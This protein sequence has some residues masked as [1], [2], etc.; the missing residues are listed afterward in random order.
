ME[1]CHEY[2]ENHPELLSDIAYT[3]AVRREHLTHR[4]Y[5]ISGVGASHVV[6]PSVRV[7]GAVADIVMTFSGQGAQWAKMGADLYLGDPEFE[8]DITDM[9]K[10]LQRLRYPPDWS[11][12]GIES[13]SRRHQ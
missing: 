5:A 6:S 8:K 9:D 13:S 10:V 7:P 4:A 2:N 11:L 3:L 1:Q 12:K